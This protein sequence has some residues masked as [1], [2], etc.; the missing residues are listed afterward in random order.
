MSQVRLQQ[1]DEILKDLNGLKKRGFENQY[2][3]DENIKFFEAIKQF[4]GNLLGWYVAAGP[5]PHDILTGNIL[6]NQVPSYAFVPNLF[7]ERIVDTAAATIKNKTN[8]PNFGGSFND[9]F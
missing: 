9:F 2:A 1:I 8:G 5:R 7:I 4:I 3:L 6:F